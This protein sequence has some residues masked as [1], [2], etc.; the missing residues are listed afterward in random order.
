LI[1]PSVRSFWTIWQESPNAARESCS[2]IDAAKGELNY[3]IGAQA[4]SK[5][6]LE[7]LIH[8][9]EVLMINHYT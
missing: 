1:T 8:S 7:E 4:V 3:F 6:Y 5:R 9:R 2:L